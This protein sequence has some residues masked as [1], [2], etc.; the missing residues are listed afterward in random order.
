[1]DANMGRPA[2]IERIQKLRRERGAAPMPIFVDDSL[3]SKIQQASPSSAS[4]QTSRMRKGKAVAAERT[5]E[6]QVN[7]NAASPAKKDHIHIAYAASQEVEASRFEPEPELQADQE[8]ATWINPATAR[9]TPRQ[10]R[11]GGDQMHIGLVATQPMVE[12]LKQRYQS[13]CSEGRPR[14]RAMSHDALFEEL[15]ARWLR[16]RGMASSDLRPELKV[17]VAPL[18]VDRVRLSEATP[19]GRGGRVVKPSPRRNI[20]SVSEEASDLFDQLD[21]D[22]DGVITRSELAAACKQGLV[23]PQKVSSVVPLPPVAGHELGRPPLAGKAVESLRLADPP[24][25]QIDDNCVHQ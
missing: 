21:Q 17:L 4:N 6:L 16:I 8:V 23:V 18:E 2:R 9:A 11:T 14:E 25:Q 20:A 7:G 10:V 5:G 19:R 12:D 1:M 15:Q 24:R 3:I 13:Y 22:G